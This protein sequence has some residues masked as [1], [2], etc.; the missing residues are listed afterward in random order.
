MMAV[1]EVAAPLRLPST[2]IVDVFGLQG[3]LL[4]VENLMMG[5]ALLAFVRVQV[6]HN[7]KR[8]LSTLNQSLPVEHVS[9][10]DVRRYTSITRKAEHSKI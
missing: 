4:P 1:L 10:L 7:K 2:L 3:H 6:C 9:P 5:K 8:N